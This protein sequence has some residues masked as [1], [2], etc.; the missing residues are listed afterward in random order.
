MLKISEGFVMPCHVIH[1]IENIQKTLLS[2]KYNFV[3]ITCCKKR[4]IFYLHNFSTDTTLESKLPKEKLLKL[5]AMTEVQEFVKEADYNFYQALVE[6]LVP[7]VLRP[8]PGRKRMD[9]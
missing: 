3:I 2:H 5:A 9:S 1:V 4:R 8:I 6:V 7:D